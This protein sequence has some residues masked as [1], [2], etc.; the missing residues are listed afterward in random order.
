MIPGS[1]LTVAARGLAALRRVLKRP[2]PVDVLKRREA[3]RDDLERN[4]RFGDDGA[5]EV[6]VI[7]LGKESEYPDADDRLIGWSSSPWFKFE[8]KGLSDRGLEV[9]RRIE[10]VRIRR[11]KARPVDDTNARKVFVVGRIPY[12]RIA[13]TDWKAQNDP[14][15]GLPRLHV[16]YGRRGP[17]REV[18]LYDMP[19]YQG[20]EAELHGVKYKPQKVRPWTRLVWSLRYRRHVGR[21]V[22][23]HR[24][25]DVR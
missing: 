14:A 25:D 18:V 19:G 3:V 10:H 13:F 22:G 20:Y 9:Y 6:V 16:A 4:L 5:P 1:E 11:S 7:R 17:F 24:Y 23:K 15:Y 12:E 21:A 2:D 8:V